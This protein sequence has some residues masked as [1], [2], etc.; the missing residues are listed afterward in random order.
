MD[1]VDQVQVEATRISARGGWQEGAVSLAV[2]YA[3]V[4]EVVLTRIMQMEE[5]MDKNMY[6]F[7]MAPVDGRAG[8]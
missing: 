3:E 1:I 6:S 7:L 5:E 2:F 4:L 8:E